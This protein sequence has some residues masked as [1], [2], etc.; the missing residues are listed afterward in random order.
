M[1]MHRRSLLALA[2]G[3]FAPAAALAGTSARAADA[4]PTAGRHPLSVLKL[5]EDLAWK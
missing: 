4:Y 1:T 2:A 3:A 5:V